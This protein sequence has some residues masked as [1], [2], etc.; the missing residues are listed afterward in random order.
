MP[1]SVK[2]ALKMWESRERFQKANPIFGIKLSP[3]QREFFDTMVDAEVRPDRL[4][5]GLFVTGSN[6]QG[7]TFCNIL[8]GI[9]LATGEHPFLPDDHP[10]KRIPNWKL[11]TVGLVVGEQ[12]TQSIDKKIVPEYQ[13]WIPKICK[14]T[15]KKNQQGTIVKITF[16]CDMQGQPLGS[17]IHMRSYD[18][19]V[20][21]F[22]G[23]DFD[24]IGYDEPPPYPHY[25]AA[26]RGLIP[27]DGIS[28]MT[29]TSLKEPWIK[30]VA[31][32]SVDMGGQSKRIRVV[33]L[34]EIW[35]NSI[36]RGG[37]LTDDAI[38]AFIKIVPKEEY[39]ARIEGKWL[40]SGSIIYSSFQ[41]ESPWVCENFETPAHWTR[42]EAVDPH[43][44]RSTKWLFCAISP[45]EVNIDDEVLNRIYV[46][47]Y[48][49]LSSTMT[50]KD[51]VREVKLERIKLNYGNRDRNC[52]VVLDAK[53]GKART[54]SLDG[55][56]PANWQEK[57]EQAGAGYVVLSHS[58]PG[59]VELGHKIVRSYLIPQYHKPSEMEIPGVVFMERC[60]GVD[61]PIESM[62]KYR[63]MI[64]TA[65]ATRKPE[66]K[67]KDHCDTLRYI[68]LDRPIYIERWGQVG[69]GG[70]DFTPRDRHAGR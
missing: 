25:V 4:P 59:D 51:M 47:N 11:P 41:N 66:E 58:K 61:S 21:T 2:E 28:F 8:R 29:F 55:E 10:L 56:E 42:V 68:C 60:Q 20:D 46:L 22:E 26:E 35:N 52:T 64:T 39:P 9:A 38:E 7:K 19:T 53:F 49:N 57:L 17:I 48:L 37:I 50:I 62:L 70:N 23:V 13:K 40:Q 54:V 45:Q 16:R 1:D 3:K 27:T 12:L 31:D 63:Y 34:G 6:K 36:K 69:G 67:Y 44:S 65:T 43:D 30:D 5:K 18:S 33:E 24:W 14:P 32:E 15:Y